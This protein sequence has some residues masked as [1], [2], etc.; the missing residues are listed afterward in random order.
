MTLS[1]TPLSTMTLILMALSAA[2]INATSAKHYER[3]VY[4]VSE[5]S[6]LRLV[7]LC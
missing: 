3:S 5:L 7:S 1:T 4:C 6:P 2:I